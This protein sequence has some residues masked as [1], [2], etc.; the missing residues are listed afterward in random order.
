MRIM[1]LRIILSGCA[2]A[3]YI[4]SLSNSF[5]VGGSCEDHVAQDHSLR[6]C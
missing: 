6:L 4:S 1:W 5:I 3:G 2:S